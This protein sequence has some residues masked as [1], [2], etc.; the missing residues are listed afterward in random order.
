MLYLA[1]VALHVM[2]A[3]LVIGLIGAVP[4]AARSGAERLVGILLRTTQFGFLGMVITGI[5][6]DVS[7]GG[8]FH[9]ASW[10]KASIVVLV[11]AGAAHARAR[12]ALKRNALQAVE[13][14]GWAMCAAI[15]VI[16]F[17]MQTK[18]LQ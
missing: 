4:L 7:S 9:R 2:T 10:F 16:T 12:A 17:L 6:L 18:P 13:R 14:W 3:V 11:L 8:N 1:S 5:L 15:A